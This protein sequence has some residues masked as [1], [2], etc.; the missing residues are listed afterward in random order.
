MCSAC[1][2]LQ[3]GFDWV[4]GVGD[5]DVTP[6]ERLAYRRQRLQLVNMMLE[7]SGVRL[8]EHGRQLVVRSATGTTR[9]VTSLAHV[10]LAADEIGRHPVDPLDPH[11]PLFSSEN[12]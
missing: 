12:L 6:H 5:D 11:S 7:G 10:W 3:G 8:A 2:I 1:G 9:I 4:E